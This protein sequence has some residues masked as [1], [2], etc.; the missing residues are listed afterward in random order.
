MKF[1]VNPKS[2]EKVLKCGVQV[3]KVGCGRQIGKCGVQVGRI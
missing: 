2:T 1:L 3:G